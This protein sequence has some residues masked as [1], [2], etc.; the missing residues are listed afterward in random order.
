[1]Y[2]EPE[3]LGWDP[4]MTLVHGPGGKPQ[5]NI[6]AISSKTATP[7]VYRTVRLISNVGTCLLRGRGTRVWEVR[8]LDANNEPTGPPRALKDSW[9]DADRPREAGVLAQ[10]LQDM[11]PEEPSVRDF[12]LTV[13]AAGDVSISGTVDCTL[14]E[15]DRERLYSRTDGQQP[16]RFDLL[17]IDNGERA[18]AQRDKLYKSLEDEVR[19]SQVSSFSALQRTL[20]APVTYSPKIHHRIVFEEVYK[21]LYEETDLAVICSALWD[22]CESTCRYLQKRTP[23]LPTSIAV[24]LMHKAGWVHRDISPGN[25]LIK[26]VGNIILVKL[27]DLE[28]AQRYNQTS[29]SQAVHEVRTVSNILA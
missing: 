1:M 18:A 17:Q 24:Q 16:R 19:G 9:P 8:M 26:V 4:T 10:V 22:V 6:Q 3:D 21:S 7:V 5:Y 20:E 23:H 29:L 2:A 25:I 12:F 15:E 28:Y 11:G 27:S 13:E 14:P